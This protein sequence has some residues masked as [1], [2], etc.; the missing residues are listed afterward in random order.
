MIFN[1]LLVLIS[2]ILENIFNL[3]LNISILFTLISLIIIF[4]YFKNAKKEYLIFSFFTGLIY[5][6]FF[7]NFYILNCFIYLFISYFIFYILKNHNFNI[8]T[9]LYSSIFAIFLYNFIL[10]IIFNFYNYTNYS[11]LDLSLILRSFIFVNI[12]YTIFIYLISKIIFYR[13][14]SYI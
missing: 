2:I 1:M 4:P 13:F 11:L 7:T 5:D 8:F 6:L 3:H 12:I 9:V 10:F 14:N